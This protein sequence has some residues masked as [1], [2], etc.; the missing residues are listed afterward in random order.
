MFTIRQV[1]LVVL[2]V[3][4]S[5]AS[6]EDLKYRKEVNVTEYIMLGIEA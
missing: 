2:V 1:M 5:A 3:L 6:L 4:A